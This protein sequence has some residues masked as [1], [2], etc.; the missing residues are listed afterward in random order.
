[1]RR[2][3]WIVGLGLAIVCPSS[4]ANENSVS[5]QL[6]GRWEGKIKGV[7]VPIGMQFSSTGKMIVIFQLG[8][9]TQTRLAF[10]VN[11][12]IDPKPNP[13][14]LDL[15]LENPKSEK[16]K[17]PVATIFDFPTPGTVRIHTKNLEPGKPRPTQF[18]QPAE[19]SKVSQSAIVFPDAAKLTQAEQSKDGEGR[20]VIQNLALSSLYHA[21]ET[22]QFPTLNQLGLGNGATQNYRYQLQAKSD[23]LTL[24]ARPTKENL[25][26]YIGVVLRFP[27]QG[28][29]YG[30][31]KVCQSVRPSR[32]AP[33]MPKIPD[34]PNGLLANY[35]IQCGLGSEAID[36]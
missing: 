10:S 33:P 22:Q 1:M 12:S 36:F 19:L 7:D 20:L 9:E 24:I 29:D 15:K 2:M 35:S 16:D 23:R 6:V 14:H 13:M 8:F 28:Q 21:L 31:T 32:I 34:S 26:S 3:S 5:Q 18:D 25:K 27:V 30:A 4:I 11:Y 17:Q